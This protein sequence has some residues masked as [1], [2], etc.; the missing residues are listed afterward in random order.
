MDQQQHKFL[1]RKI[2]LDN[3]TSSAEGFI[4]SP[5]P[6]HNHQAVASPSPL[7]LPLVL[8]S[9]HINKIDDH[10]KGGRPHTQPY[11]QAKG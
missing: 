10:C 5:I 11:K 2:N 7:P 1:Y 8:T 6:V 3:K 4:V 9:A